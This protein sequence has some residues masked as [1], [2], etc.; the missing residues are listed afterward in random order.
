[1]TDS[2]SPSNTRREFIKSGTAAAAGLIAGASTSQ[3]QQGP[4]L[5]DSHE[6]TSP[7]SAAKSDTGNEFVSETPKEFQEFSR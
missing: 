2:N 5:T 6:S 3:A 7:M 4:T 1:M